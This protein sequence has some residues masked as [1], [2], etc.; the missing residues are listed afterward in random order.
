[1]DK[2]T[3]SLNERSF[4][5]FIHQILVK[6]TRSSFF[7]EINSRHFNRLDQAPHGHGLCGGIFA[8][9]TAVARRKP[10]GRWWASARKQKLVDRRRARKEEAESGTGGAA[11]NPMTPGGGGNDAEAPR[12]A[13]RR[14][15]VE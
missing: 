2:I 14:C 15:V 12:F 11:S 1:V 10:E 13:R 3:E 6:K 5:E 4:E 7:G 8:G 9:A